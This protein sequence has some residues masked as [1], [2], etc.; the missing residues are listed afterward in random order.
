MAPH[1]HMTAFAMKGGGRGVTLGSLARDPALVG[2]IP[3]KTFQGEGLSSQRRDSEVSFSSCKLNYS[4]A[5]YTV[6]PYFMGGVSVP[7]LIIVI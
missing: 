2:H 6:R 1:D 7:G 4:V 5:L 3:L